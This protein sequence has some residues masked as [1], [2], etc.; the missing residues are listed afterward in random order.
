MCSYF[1]ENT[2]ERYSFVS[3]NWCKSENNSLFFYFFKSKIKLKLRFIEIDSLFSNFQSIE[4]KILMFMNKLLQLK[5]VPKFLVN[6]F[7]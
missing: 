7:Y 6:I 3:Q 2:K 4:I 1:F 5:I